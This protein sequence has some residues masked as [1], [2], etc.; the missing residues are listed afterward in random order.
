MNNISKINVNG[1]TYG[2]VD[3]ITTINGKSGAIDAS[4]I[5]A[6]LSAAGYKLTDDNTVTTINGKTG[7]IDAADIASVLTTA[8]YELTDTTYTA[9][10]GVTIT[11]GQINVT[12]GNAANTACQG[13]DVRLSDSRPAS[14]V[15]SWAK[16]STK[17]EYTK[18]EI[19]LENVTNHAQV[20][21]SEMGV[22]SGVATL[23]SN[24]QVPSSQLLN[25]STTTCQDIVDELV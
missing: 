21:R 20:K 13:N 15:Y 22:A 16:A 23:D 14:D 2:I 4:D 9:G 17:P 11:S 18:S 24:G 25:A 3:T 12:Y 8:G 1:T 10:T 19:G 5:A 6:V 7:T